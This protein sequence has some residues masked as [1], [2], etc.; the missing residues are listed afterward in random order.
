M[1]KITILA[2]VTTGSL[3]VYADLPIHFIFGIVFVGIM[4]EIEKI[5]KKAYPILSNLFLS[6]LVGWAVSF[7]VKHFFPSLFIGDIKI[8]MIFI[9]TVFSYVTV[10]Y[11]LKNETIQKL[12]ERYLNKKNGNN[13]GN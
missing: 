3:L 13:S 10:I 1:T 11:V 4:I 6:T 7:G 2:W 12:V 5:E 8:F 9:T